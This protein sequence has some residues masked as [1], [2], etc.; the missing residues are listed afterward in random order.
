MVA[1]DLPSP[2]ALGAPA[3]FTAWRPRQVEAVLY[4]LDTESRFTLQ[5]MPTG[6]GKSPTVVSRALL[7]GR[8]TAFLTVNK[9][10]EDQYA[11]DFAECG[12]VDVRGQNSYECVALAK[13]EFGSPIKAGCDEGPCHHEV[14]CAHKM[15][16]CLY[17]EAY[18]KASSAQLVVTNYAYWLS[19]NAYN[20]EGL[21]DFDELVLDEAHEAPNALSSF[22]TIDLDK[23]EAEGVLGT[24]MPNSTMADWRE[25]ARVN[26]PRAKQ[27]YDDALDEFQ[28]LSDGGGR[29]PHGLRREVKM[30]KALIAK[31]TRISALKGH[32]LVTP[33]R[34]GANLEPIWPAPYAEDYLFIKIPHVN[35]ISATLRPKTAQLLGIKDYD[36]AEYPSSFAVRR[37][38]VM[39]VP[40]VKLTY[41]SSAAD[42]AKWV[43]RIDEIIAPRLDRKGIIHTVS[44][45]R[46]K[47]ILEKSRFANLMMVNTS[48]NTAGTVENFKKASS[49]RILA[50]PSLSTGWDFPYSECEYQ[51]I[52]KI[53]FPDSSDPI[54]AARSKDDPDYAGY[55]AMMTLV[56][57][58]GRGMRAPDDQCEIFIVDDNAKWFMFRFR[59]FAPA[60]FL[61][62]VKW[63][64]EI[65]APLPLLGSEK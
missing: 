29:P 38:P 47:A 21:G 65:P 8:R 7:T 39:H 56:Q 6:F 16:D 48:G 31:L 34:N 44:Y 10:L 2:A 63:L 54:I 46:Q 5:S 20:P 30:L 18:R 57:A 58:A 13:G 9:G 15:N 12:L 14:N 25:W 62:S 52:S 40:T 17:F 64:K 41:K 24:R 3:K 28:E 51:I 45:T 37:R 32:W 1:F 4:P 33:R 22:L 50:S 36:F 19:I 27:M 26:L 49:P 35:L 53:P 11:R 42:I 61:N 55:I 43:T 59:Q 23:H 60:W